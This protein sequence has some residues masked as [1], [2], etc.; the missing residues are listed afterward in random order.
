MVS[1][2]HVGRC[3]SCLAVPMYQPNSYPCYSFH[4]THAI[5]YTTKMEVESSA[6]LASKGSKGNK[7]KYSDAMQCSMRA[8]VVGEEVT[9]ELNYV[10]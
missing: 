10:G 7:K 4:R 3:L 1:C 6:D 5:D 2:K 9:S 8:R